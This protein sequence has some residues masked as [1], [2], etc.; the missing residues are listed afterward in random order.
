MIDLKHRNDWNQPSHCFFSPLE[1]TVKPIFQNNSQAKKQKANSEAHWRKN[2][3]QG[4]SRKQKANSE[5]PWRIKDRPRRRGVSGGM[6][7][8]C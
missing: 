1:G 2:S 7:G 3:K 5:A 8:R 6:V 4:E